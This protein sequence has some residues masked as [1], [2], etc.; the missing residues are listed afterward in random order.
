[1]SAPV[2]VAML[3]SAHPPM[4]VRIFL[5]EARTL[6]AA[7][8]EVTYV[9]PHDRDEQV[10]GVRLR[11]F[12]RP[13]HRLLRMFASPPRMLREALRERADVYHFHDPE[14]IP[15]GLALK[16]LGKRVVYDA[17]EDVAKSILGKSYLARWVRRPLAAAV[18]LLEKGASRAFDLVV[19][20]AGGIQTSFQGYAHTLLIRNYPIQELQAPG[21]PAVR[22][23]GRLVVAYAGGLTAQRGAVEMVQ[24]IAQVPARYEPRLVICGRYWPAELEQRVRSMPGFERVDYQGWLQPDRV[25]AALRQADAGL[26]CFLPEP[27]HVEAGPN[28]LFEYMAAGLPVIASAFPAWREIVEE[29]DCGLCVDPAE[30]AAIA[31][32]IVWLAEHPQRRA[33]MG[34]NGQ[35]LVRERYNWEAE[36]RRLIEA[37]AS[38]SLRNRA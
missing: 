4:D 33:E 5:K 32:A 15:V 37:Y 19:V 26:V 11:A 8:Y 36:A 25:T 7:G 16:V 27:N 21:E 3:S 9:V 2:R 29:G 34:R 30:P 20:A 12:P 17:H 18:N 35:R 24:A 10:D 38:I 22:D 23:D 14:L 13:R 28:K 31:E 6:A 1:V